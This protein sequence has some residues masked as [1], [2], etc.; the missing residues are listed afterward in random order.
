MEIKPL[1]LRILESELIK[2]E[3]KYLNWMETLRDEDPGTAWRLITIIQKLT[4]LRR[5]ITVLLENKNG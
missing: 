1:G 4:S 5:E 3:N 2:D